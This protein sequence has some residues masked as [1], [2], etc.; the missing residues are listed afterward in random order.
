MSESEDSPI[1]SSGGGEGALNSLRNFRLQKKKFTPGGLDS[2]NSSQE[3]SQT[4]TDQSQQNQ[5]E[6]STNY[7]SEPESPIRPAGFKRVL[8][9]RDSSPPITECSISLNG[10]RPPAH[11][12]IRMVSDSESENGS[13]PVKGAAV[14]VAIP[15][16]DE[17]ERKVNFLATACPSVDPMVLQDTLRAHDW[18]VDWAIESLAP[19]E[20]M[21]QPSLSK[22]QDNGYINKKVKAHHVDED[23]SE[24]DDDEFTGKGLVYDSDEEEEGPSNDNLTADKKKVL[25]FFNEGGE[26]E[27]TAIQGCNKKKVVEIIKLRPFEGWVDLVTKLQNNRGLSAEILNSATELLRMK[28]AVTKLMNKCQKITA[29]RKSVV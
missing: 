1:K 18:N 8:D 24:S 4:T 5:S 21:K 22:K 27:M 26:Q 25:K 20:K 6:T 19:K 7:Q 15:S 13:S 2:D 12:R 14:A 16:P 23:N 28:S 11:K 10:A 29:D 17:I 9:C 3:P